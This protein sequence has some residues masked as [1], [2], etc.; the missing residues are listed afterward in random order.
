[1]LKVRVDESGDYKD[2]YL[3][4]EQMIM[5]YAPI[6]TTGNDSCTCAWKN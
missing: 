4:T 1:M 6:V 5:L 2:C 3:G